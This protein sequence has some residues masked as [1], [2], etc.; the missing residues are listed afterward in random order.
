[1]IALTDEEI[2]ACVADILNGDRK[3][4]VM[5]G[6]CYK[7]LDRRGAYF[8]GRDV[9]CQDCLTSN[10]YHRLPQFGC[11]AADVRR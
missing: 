6:G 7:W 2:A 9:R 10:Y 3:E 4:D 8:N 11:D 5:C 1:M